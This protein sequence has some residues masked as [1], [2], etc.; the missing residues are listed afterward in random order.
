MAHERALFLKSDAGYHSSSVVG[1][2][3]LIGAPVP[4]LPHFPYSAQK[5]QQRRVRK[6]KNQHRSSRCTESNGRGR[7]DEHAVP[8]EPRREDV[9][10]L[11]FVTTGPGDWSSMVPANNICFF[12]ILM[13]AALEGQRAHKRSIRSSMR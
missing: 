5:T 1:S 4:E 7:G 10:S 12:Q 8:T 6:P 11:Y 9:K 3:F 2:V 13:G